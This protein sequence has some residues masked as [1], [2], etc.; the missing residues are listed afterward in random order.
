MVRLHVD[1]QPRAAVIGIR[2]VTTWLDFKFSRGDFKRTSLV[3]L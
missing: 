3:I 2:H 1:V